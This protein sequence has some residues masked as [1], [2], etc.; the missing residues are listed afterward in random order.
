MHAISVSLEGQQ[1]AGDWPSQLVKFSVSD[2]VGCLA[3]AL[4]A[5]EVRN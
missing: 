2:E 4:E 5:F 3:K 1:Q